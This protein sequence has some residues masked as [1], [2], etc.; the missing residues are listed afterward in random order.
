MI[1]YENINEIIC[2]SGH[3]NILDVFIFW[4]GFALFASWFFKT[5]YGTRSLEDSV[6]R[7]NNLPAFVPMLLV[8][9]VLL[10]IDFFSRL[11]EVL[12]K[13]L[14]KW[15]QVFI[16]EIMHSVLGLISIGV[17]LFIVR[18]HFVRGLRGFG[19]NIKTIPKDFGLAFVSLLAI[20][21]LIYL[22]LTAVTSLNEMIYGSDYKIPTHVELKTLAENSNLM[23]KIAIAVATVGVVPFLEE[24][25][26]RGFFQTMIRSETYFF[27]HSAWI[28][29]FITSTF[30]SLFHA[31][32]SH[33]PALFILG[34]CMGYSYEKSGSLFRPVFI[35]M[36]FNASAVI[37][38]WLK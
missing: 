8:F 33:W 12:S 7:R 20:W 32:A 31:N 16:T 2:A 10:L 6:P 35:H 14:P 11:S 9:A 4:G 5:S 13:D 30:F 19:L 18:I 34:A 36:L 1:I 3:I 27:K 29:I 25:L 26:F 22:V 15:Q 21:P 24:I 37:P 28:A 38:T 17:I 23:V